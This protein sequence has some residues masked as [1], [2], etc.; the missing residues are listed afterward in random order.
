MAL[1][2]LL[3]AVYSNTLAHGGVV[4]EDDICVI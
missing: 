1:L 4:E 3:L 2:F